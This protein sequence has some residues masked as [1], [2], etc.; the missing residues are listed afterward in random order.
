MPL[1]TV[2]YNLPAH[3]AGALINGDAMPAD[4]V[5]FFADRPNLNPD[6]LDASEAWFSAW[7][8][9]VDHYVGDVI[10]FT[11]SFLYRLWP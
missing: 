5:K 8:C 11:F 3:W 9:D 1:A 7:D 2:E 4:A 6:A 10:R